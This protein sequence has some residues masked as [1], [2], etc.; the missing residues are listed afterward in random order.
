MP[1]NSG[2][3]VTEEE[4]QWIM[5]L[6]YEERYQWT[7]ELLLLRRSASGPW[8]RYLRGEMPVDSGVV[9]VEKER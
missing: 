5:E 4:R 7:V 2:V 6:F 1:V 3:V 8:N 9:V